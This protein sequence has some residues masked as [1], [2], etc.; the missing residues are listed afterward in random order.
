V[1]R[2]LRALALLAVFG[3]RK[4][5]PAHTGALVDDAGVRLALAATPARVVS[6]VPATTELVFALGAGSLLVGRTAWCDYP[7]DAAA[8]PNLGNGIDPN[9]EA[10]VAAK[11]DLVLLY[12][13]GAN[14]AA[15]ERLRA[16]GIPTLE[17]ATD[18][19]EDFD[20]IT[21]LLGAALGRPEEAESLV[22]RTARDL[23]ASSRSPVLPSS[24]RPSVFI[25]AWDRPAMTLGRGSFLSEIL[26]HAG[27]RNVFDD[28]A[29][30]SAPVSIEAVA[31]RN[32]D[33]V[34]VSSEGEP[35]VAGRDEW[36]VVPAVRERRFLRVRGS[37]FNRP[38]PRIGSAVRQLAAALDSLRR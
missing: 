35:E 15:A 14:R 12:K 19:M 10:V 32:P 27:A 18:R 26:E 28:L 6:L 1:H 33:Y 7:A 21:R 31:A 22:V 29:T 16:L 20:R 3:C 34:L 25:L 13:S 30:S 8:V 36:R 2:V 9:V 5:P 38:S 4:A 11:P 24:R 17:L 23:A 37:E